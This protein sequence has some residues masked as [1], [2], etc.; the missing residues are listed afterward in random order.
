[1]IVTPFAHEPTHKTVW[2][3]HMNGNVFPRLT[4]WDVDKNGN[5]FLGLTLCDI[6]TYGNVFLGFIC[7]M[8]I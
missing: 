3:V 2:D 7:G 1:M 5:T 6:H 8:Y 4:V